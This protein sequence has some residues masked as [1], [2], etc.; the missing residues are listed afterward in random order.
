MYRK[1][2]AFNTVRGLNQLELTV[3]KCISLSGA[4]FSERRSKTVDSYCLS[5]LY[6]PY[7]LDVEYALPYCSLKS[8]L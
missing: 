6:C 8:K 7:Q 3:Q 5:K 4:L 2:K 1:N